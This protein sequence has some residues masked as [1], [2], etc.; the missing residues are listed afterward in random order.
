MRRDWYYY[1]ALTR[2]LT[3]ICSAT[4]GFVVCIILTILLASCKHI[5]Y[6]PVE[7]VKTEYKTKVDSFIQKD[8]IFIKDSV[9]IHSKGDT[10]WY[11][12]WHTQFKDRIV[13]ETLRDTVIK[14]D[15]VQVP[16]PIERKP[17]KWE[18]ICMDYG[19]LMMGGTIV[20][21]IMIIV[22]VIWWIRR[23]IVL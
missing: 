3:L 6:V 11:E 19:K 17:T 15:S 13:F 10:I 21:V 4:V 5:E 20:T 18:Q 16:V 12:K 23:K 8:S 22:I 1:H 14:V 7:V 9:F 2:V